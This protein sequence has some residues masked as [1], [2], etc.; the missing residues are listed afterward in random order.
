GKPIAVKIPFKYTFT[1]PPSALSGRVVT[2][3]GEHPLA[4]A[5]VVVTDSAQQSQ[6]VTTDGAGAWRV[7]GL[8]AGTYPLSIPAAGRAPHEADEAVAAG[9][10]ATSVDRLASQ[11]AA[12][13]T[14]T[15]G[16]ATDVQE[17]EVHGEKPP[18]SLTKRTLEQREL[19]RIPGTNG[20][21]LKSLM[22]LP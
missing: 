9:E 18:R 13:S 15:G 21:A 5:T 2:L 20:D 22:N 11:E 16:P 7:E 17:V 12:P 8:A 10:E 4:G 14:T 6:T 1:P 3:V 19:S